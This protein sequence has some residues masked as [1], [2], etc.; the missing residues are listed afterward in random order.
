MVGETDGV[1]TRSHANNNQGISD[2]DNIVF[3]NFLTIYANIPAGIIVDGGVQELIGTDSYSTFQLGILHFRELHGTAVVQ[4]IIA[5]LE[6]CSIQ[7]GEINFNGPIV[8]G[9]RAVDIDRDASL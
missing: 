5:F 2:L 9:Y 6:F 8:F 1:S 4:F 3:E 7:R